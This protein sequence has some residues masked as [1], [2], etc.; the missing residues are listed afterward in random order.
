MPAPA[1][2]RFRFSLR[3]LLISLP[4]VGIAIWW[5]GTYLVMRRAE[6]AYQRTYAEW[7]AEMVTTTELCQRSQDLLAAELIVPL[8]DRRAAKER[9]LERITRIREKVE[10]V[11]LLQTA[12]DNS[13]R[14]HAHL[15]QLYGD[16]QRS[17]DESQ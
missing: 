12:G 13:L 8:A 14:E 3:T 6:A 10:A 17:V 5:T 16:A 9:H 15:Q 4:L 11:R 1:A 7:E 2:R